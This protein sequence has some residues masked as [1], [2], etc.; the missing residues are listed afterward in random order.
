V[1]Y[2][3]GSC[4]ADFSLLVG[5]DVLFSLIYYDAQLFCAFRAFYIY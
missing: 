4:V 1:S 2:L 3:G 5:C